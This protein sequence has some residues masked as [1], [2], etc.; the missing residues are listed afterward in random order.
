VTRPAEAP[1]DVTGD[2]L[3]RLLP[4]LVEADA[5]VVN[6]ERRGHTLDG[7]LS[8]LKDVEVSGTKTKLLPAFHVRY[9]GRDEWFYSQAE[10]EAFRALESER[11]GK[12]L[13]LADT[14]AALKSTGGPATAA[15]AAPGTPAPEGAS[16]SAPAAPAAPA[17]TPATEPVVERY[18]LDEWHEVRTLNRVVGK[19][20]A[21]GFDFG[22]LVP[23]PR[24]AGR[25][26]PTRFAVEHGEARRELPHLLLL[27]AE[28]R[29]FGE[30]GIMV[31]RFK[32]LG[33]MDPEELWDTTLNPQ[34]R[35]LLRVTL[36]DALKAEELFRTLM[37]EEVEGRKQFIMN[38]T[39]SSLEDIDYGA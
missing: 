4:L 3:S 15:A 8:K 26:P 34:H 17:P 24:L 22:D 28:I 2:D 18:T 23:L 20:R 31:T 39:I 14:L 11:I 33:E 6:L 38:R 29:K 36:T 13:V 25:E 32:G 5:A 21:L 19:L 9:A 30:K 35:T 37:G 7:Y 1:R 12:E 10:V 27:V 16:P